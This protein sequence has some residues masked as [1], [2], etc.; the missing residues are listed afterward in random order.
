MRAKDHLGPEVSGLTVIRHGRELS[1]GLFGFFQRERFVIE[2]EEAPGAPVA[3]LARGPLEP[4]APDRLAALAESTNDTVGV[5]F[6]QELQGVLEDAEAVVADAAGTP[7]A[8][9][10][11]PTVPQCYLPPATETQGAVSFGTGQGGTTAIRDRLF[12]AGLAEEYL[13]DPLFSQPALALPLRLGAMAAAEPVLQNDGDVLVLLGEVPESL[14]VAERLAQRR[15]EPAEE[16]V[17]I[18]SHR[19]LTQFGTYAR[20]RSAK[21]AGTMVLDRRLAGSR[22]I[23]VVDSGCRNGFVPSTV[24]GLRPEATWAVVPASWDL[25]RVRG[26]E[27]LVGRLGAIALYGVVLTDHFAGLIGR[28]WPLAYLDG[29]EASPLSVAARLIEAIGP[30]GD[31]Q[32]LG[33]NGDD[34]RTQRSATTVAM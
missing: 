30:V 14:A 20:A 21:E 22:S 17:I 11:L 19:R 16:A 15:D 28:D 12:A 1:G 26:L 33:A 34:A 27:Q 4:Q 31:H 5:S 2:L 3:D 13:P 10:Y 6:D 18:V 24:A 8:T 9:G 7:G 29:W 23:A 32:G 25:K